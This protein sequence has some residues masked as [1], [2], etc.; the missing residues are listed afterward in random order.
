MADEQQ[1]TEE[2]GAGTDRASIL[3]DLRAQQAQQTEEEATETEEGGEADDE[4]SDPEEG[5]GKGDDDEDEGEGE[6]DD[7]DDEVAEKGVAK[8]Q[9]QERRAREAIAAERQAFEQE[10][11]QW[12]Q[13]NAPLVDKAKKFDAIAERFRADPVGV[14]ADLGLSEEDYDYIAEQFFRLSKKAGEDPRH[15][16]AARIARVERELAERRRRE[17]REAEDRRKQEQAEQERRASAQAAQRYMDDLGEAAKK[18]GGLAQRL[19]GQDPQ[20]A[21]RELALV[22]SE[23]LRENPDATPRAVLKRFEAREAKRLKAHGIDPATLAAPARPKKKKPVAKKRAE[24][25]EAT[26]AEEAPKPKNEREQIIAELREFRKTK[27][28]GEGDG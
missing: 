6:D 24:A 20:L 22:A 23:V 9:R 4:E 16:E 19:L 27:G 25:S 7:D 14:A 21:H 12:R 13:E 26:A 28:E 1:T 15:R 8:V 10:K 18:R 3:A 2:T 11:A 5:E 17:E